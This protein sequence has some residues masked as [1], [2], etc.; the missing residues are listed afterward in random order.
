MGS[1]EHCSESHCSDRST[2]ERSSVTGSAMTN[3]DIMASLEIGFVVM[4]AVVGEY[5]VTVY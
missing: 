5:V 2:V 4:S 3:Y 1:D